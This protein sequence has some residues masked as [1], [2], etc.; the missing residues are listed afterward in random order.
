MLIAAIGLVASLTA[1]PAATRA[2]AA[3]PATTSAAAAPSA[4]TPATVAASVTA[5][6]TLAPPAAAGSS[7][8]A[9][10]IQRKAH[11]VVYRM[12]CN[13]AYNVVKWAL[14]RLG[15]RASDLDVEAPAD[16]CHHGPLGQVGIKATFSV[17][18]PIDAKLLAQLRERF[19]PE[20]SAAAIVE[21]H[22]QTV[23]LVPAGY[24]L[25][26]GNAGGGSRIGGSGLGNAL[27]NC[28]LPNLVKQQIMPLFFTRNVQLADCNLRSEEL[29]AAPLPD[30]QYL[31][32][33][34]HEY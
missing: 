26:G 33:L 13:T 30:L 31:L 25:S 4:T 9:V 21:A 17:L 22:W 34:E 1:D 10:W 5:P 19:G 23:E 7:Q 12:P 24:S 18:A 20:K 14:L 15:A 27:A 3:P 28:F 6:A 11:V 2:A 16:E 32:R 29:T 8:N